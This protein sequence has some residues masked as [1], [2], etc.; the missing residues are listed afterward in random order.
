L[1]LP[2]SSAAFFPDEGYLLTEPLIARL[3]AHVGDQD[4]SFLRRPRRARLLRLQA[5]LPVRLAA[6]R[7]R[8]RQ[9]LAADCRFVV[10]CTV[11]ASRRQPG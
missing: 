2:A 8:K 7:F 9:R 6:C 3:V 10:D 5:L 1:R 4:L 11:H